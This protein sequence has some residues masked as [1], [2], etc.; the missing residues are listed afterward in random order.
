MHVKARDRVGHTLHADGI[1]VILGVAAVDRDGEKVAE[2]LAALAFFVGDARPVKRR[3]LFF[4]GVGERLEQ[5]VRAQN[6][7]DV[8]ALVLRIAQV[9]ANHT[10]GGHSVFGIGA[11]FQHNALAVLRTVQKT[12]VDIDRVAQLHL[13]RLKARRAAL[14]VD[15]ADDVFG[16]SLDDLLDAPF[17]TFAV[18]L[19]RQDRAKHDIPVHRAG[20][21]VRRNEKIV[22][23]LIADK[24]EAARRTLK[25]PAHAPRLTRRAIQR[26]AAKEHAFKQRVIDRRVDGL[27]P[28]FRADERKSSSRFTA[29]PHS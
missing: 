12:L 3:G 7:R 29:W 19:R 21:G 14:Q 1:V 17:G 11:H 22:P 8:A 13:V 18:H 5:P 16:L 15:D 10:V 23:E 9:F 20:H 27:I 25:P 26:V 28:L 2:I 24:A 6:G 4:D